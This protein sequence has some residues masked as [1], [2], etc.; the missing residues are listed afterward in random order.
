MG[1]PFWKKAN[2][3]PL[4]MEFCYQAGL[5]VTHTIQAFLFFQRSILD[6][7]HETGFL[8]EFNNAQSHLLYQRISLFFDE[9]LMALVG[10]YFLQSTT[11]TT[12]HS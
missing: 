1:E 7:V 10:Q 2:D 9:M 4:V 11:H 5:S 6:A 8:G 12:P 3:S